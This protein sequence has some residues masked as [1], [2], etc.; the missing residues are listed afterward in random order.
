M[1]TLREVLERILSSRLSSPSVELANA[2]MDS[3]TWT[4]AIRGSGTAGTYQI[5][6]QNCRYSRIG[7][8]IFLDLNI[9]MAAAVTGGGTG[10]LNITGVPFAKIADAFPI[11]AVS[12]D[13]LDWT[14]GALLALTFTT[15]GAGSTLQIRETNDNAAAAGLAVSA[16]AANDVI[17]GSISYETADA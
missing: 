13:G 12:L 15:A 2:M 14:A 10:A 1:A 5:L 16:I 7:R 6:S 17:A 4:A 11:G 9:T 8:R 3:S